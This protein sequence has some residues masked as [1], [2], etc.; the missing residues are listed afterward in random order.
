MGIAQSVIESVRRGRAPASHPAAK[1]ELVESNS[2][3]HLIFKT[4]SHIRRRSRGV[5][6]I[7][8]FD[9]LRWPLGNVRFLSPLL[10][11]T[12]VDFAGKFVGNFE[13]VVD[14]LF[15]V[16]AGGVGVLE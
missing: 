1:P 16:E 13:I 7:I 10:P 2:K 3:W 15:E 12:A 9:V 14:D 8:A 5:N 4:V 11:R 6:D